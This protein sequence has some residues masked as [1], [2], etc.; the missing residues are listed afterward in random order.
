MAGF[1]SCVFKSRLR[2]HNKA[3]R[4]AAAVEFAMVGPFFIFLIC[5]AFDL[6]LLLFTQSVLNN[7]ARDAS[8]LI[9]TNQAATSSSAFTTQL[10]NDM[11]GMVPC[12]D[13]QYYVQSGATF[14]AMNASVQTNSGGNLQSNGVY[15]PGTPGEDVIVQV[16]YNRPTL[17]PWSLEYI[18]GTSSLLSKS[19][20]LLV[21][22]VV[23]QNEP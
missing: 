5:V 10:C 12:G 6:G 22:T 2:A 18:N 4:G 15:L 14:S 13:L 11:E 3:R 7:A 21:A 19:T 23:F 9:M 17:M 16:A 8:R 20:N 1:L